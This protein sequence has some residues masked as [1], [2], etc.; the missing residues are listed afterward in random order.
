METVLEQIPH[1]GNIQLTIQINADFH[2][3]AKAAQRLAR[4]FVADEISYLL[5]VEDPSLVAGERLCWRLPIVLALPAH[6]TVGQVG[7]VDV[8]VET[9]RLLLT[10][11]QIN[12]IR[13][14]ARKLGEGYA[15]AS[16]QS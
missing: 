6:G 14:Q 10:M 8:D 9:G 1:T 13:D 12:L 15:A 7:V 4:R 3:S 11:E 5:R 16:F 2:Y